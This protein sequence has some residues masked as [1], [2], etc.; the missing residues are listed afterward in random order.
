MLVVQ[1]GQV[2]S[3]EGLAVFREA[4]QRGMHFK[5]KSTAIDLPRDVQAVYGSVRFCELAMGREVTPECYPEWTRPFWHREIVTVRTAHNGRLTVITPHSELNFCKP[6]WTYKAG[7]AFFSK[8]GETYA[9]F[10]AY[11]PFYLSTVV[12]FV[13]EWR[14]YVADGEVWA[15]GQ[16]QGTSARC[17]DIPPSVQIPSGWCG[18]IDIGEL[19]T[20]EL[21]L[22]ECHHPYA[23]GWYGENEEQNLY[24]DWMI[25]GWDWM[26]Q[27]PHTRG[28]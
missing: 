3:R 9:G 7:V 6:A 17:P 11:A 12:R 1:E 13:R 10:P 26:K 4:L 28:A 22:V 14:L 19:A 27:Q 24:V 25:A 18:T 23:C 15:G 21:A 8:R 20:G 5:V 2:N 16:Y